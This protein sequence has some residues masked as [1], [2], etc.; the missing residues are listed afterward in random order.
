MALIWFLFFKNETFFMIRPFSIFPYLV[1]WSLNSQVFARSFKNL[2]TKK[3]T[4]AR[5]FLLPKD[6]LGLMKKF[7]EKISKNKFIIPLFNFF[8]FIDR[9]LHT[10]SF[11]LEF[12]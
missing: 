2:K 7:G 10:F 8:K 1:G 4:F 5:M 9:K 11:V 6:F 12:E 3:K